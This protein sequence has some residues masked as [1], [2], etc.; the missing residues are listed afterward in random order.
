MQTETDHTSRG[1]GGGGGYFTPIG[2][3]YPLFFLYQ[4]RFLVKTPHLGGGGGGGGG[5][6]RQLERSISCYYYTIAVIWLRLS[7][8]RKTQNNQSCYTIRVTS[9]EEHVSL[10]QLR[11][12]YSLKSRIPRKRIIYFSQKIAS[13]KIVIDS[14]IC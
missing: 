11:S 5:T 1:W 7:I 12:K 2:A 9:I 10:P 13:L 14:D 6:S 3:Q 8:L 4:P